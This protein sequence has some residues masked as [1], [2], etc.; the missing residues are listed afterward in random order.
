MPKFDSEPIQRIS[1]TDY[2]FIRNKIVSILGDTDGGQKGY[3]QAIHSSP[4]IAGEIIRKEQW[5]QLRLDILNTKLHQDGVYPPII[6]LGDDSN[7]DLLIGYS[8]DFPNTNYNTISDTAILNKFNIG[9]GQSIVS[10][11]SI[12]N[13]TSPGT[14][15]KTGSWATQSQC[16]LTVTFT[17]GYTV[18]NNN[19]STFVASGA[20]HARHFFNSGGKIRFT[21]SRTGGSTTAQN[22]AWTALLSTAVG[23]IQFGATSFVGS[24]SSSLYTTITTS[25]SVNFYTLTTVPQEF[26][27]LN[28]STPYSLNSFKIDASINS[29][30]DTIT[31]TIT[32]GDSYVD[33]G[34]PAPGDLVNGTL[35]LSIEEFKATGMMLPSGNFTI[36]SPEY[37]F[38]ASGIIQ[39]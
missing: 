38:G 37:E 18:D 19:G 11:P 5:D 20:D 7:S 9:V 13:E 36:L 26:Y 6:T 25:S 28:A 33:P 17:G 12:D 14:I 4:V 34:L 27:K 16:T 8:E 22:N 23:T 29:L 21:S 39:T 30:A 15:S 10:T 2:N 24:E 35:T 1:A 31:F 32:W 3:G